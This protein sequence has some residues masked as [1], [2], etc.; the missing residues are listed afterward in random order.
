METFERENDIS[1]GNKKEGEKK[2]CMINTANCLWMSMELGPNISDIGNK[3]PEDIYSC[4][5]NIL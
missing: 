5:V 2:Q 4:S 3:Y 1:T